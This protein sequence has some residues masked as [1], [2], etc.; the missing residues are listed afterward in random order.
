M[1]LAEVNDKLKAKE[2]LTL[3]RKLYKNDQNWISPLDDNINAIF[4]PLR[5]NYFK[6]GTC[7]RWILKDDKGDCIGRIAAFINEHKAYT[8]K[9]PTGGFGFFECIKR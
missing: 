6:H 5:N 8:Q 2:F 1:L 9:L 3:P 4:D 7:N